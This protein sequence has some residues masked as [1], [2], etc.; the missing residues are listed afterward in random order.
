MS[1]AVVDAFLALLR[2]YPR[3]TEPLAT[4]TTI[5]G[6]CVVCVVCVYV[7]AVVRIAVVVVVVPM[8]VHDVAATPV[9]LE[10]GPCSTQHKA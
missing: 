1:S 2:N 4:T 10:L 9:H 3:E 5:C 8:A 6:C 7:V